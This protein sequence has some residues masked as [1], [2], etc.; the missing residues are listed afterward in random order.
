GGNIS[1]ALH[2]RTNHID[3]GV[4]ATVVKRLLQSARDLAET[5]AVQPH[6]N[7]RAVWNLHVETLFVR[8]HACAKRI[9]APCLC[10]A[11]FVHCSGSDAF[12]HAFSTMGLERSD[13]TKRVGMIGP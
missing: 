13:S 8:L 10:I 9:L 7:R 5:I 3:H 6:K 11:R 12:G 2:Q 1:E 4:L